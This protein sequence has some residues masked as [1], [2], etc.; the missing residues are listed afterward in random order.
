MQGV[1][2]SAMRIFVTQTYG[3]SLFLVELEV[4]ICAA[5]TYGTIEELLEFSYD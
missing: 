3:G 1:V 5:A 2:G 4:S